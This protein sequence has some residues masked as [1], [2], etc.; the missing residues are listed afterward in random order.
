MT[1]LFPLGLLGLIGVPIIVIIYILRNKYNE[2]TVPSTY[3]WKLSERFFKRRNPLS[4]LT[5]IIS[6]ILQILTVITISLAVA[7]PIFVIPNSASE[8]CFVLDASGSMNMQ[9][10]NKTRFELAKSKIKK[11]INGAKAGS[12]YTL[13]LVSNET[14]SYERLT[15]KKLAIDTLS[16]F[17]CSDGVVSYTD[18]LAT[19]QRYFDE[20]PSFRVYLYTDKNYE[21][22]TN[23]ELVNVSN[24]NDVN[25]AL[26]DVESS[27]VNKTLTAKSNVTSY[28]SD[29]E[30]TV[31]LF[32]D[33]GKT[34]SATT[35]VSVKSGET[36]PVSLSTALESY[37]SFKLCIENEDALPTDNEFISYNQS[38]E[39]DYRILIVSETPFFLQAAFDAACDSEVDTL[40]P[41]EY[42]L[43]K[44]DEDYGLYVFHSYTPETLPDAAV[45]LINSTQS[46][47][48]SGFGI[49]GIE[50]LDSPAKLEKNDSTATIAQKLLTGIEGKDIYVKEYVKCS[51]MY[52]KFTTLFSY[53]SNPLLFAGV[54]ALGNRQV[55]F[56][57]D[58]HKAH[59]SLSID[60]SLLIANLLAYSCPDVLD[61]T[62]YVCGEEVNINIIANAKN[63]KAVAPDGAEIYIDSSTDLGVIRLNKVG[64]YTVRMNVSGEEKSYKFYSCA[65]TE[66]S[67][68]LP[69]G[70]AFSLAGEQQFEK[71]DG[72]YD[73]LAI[74]F[75]CLTLL[76]IADWMVYCYEKYQLR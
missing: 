27:L 58:L 23:I 74:L 41:E 1:F 36:V 38:S 71:T 60:K 42:D 10:E 72:T 44:A 70:L 47:E 68:P 67:D 64:T 9:S 20:N 2:Q 29:A 12:S 55:V 39:A 11:T 34:P 76:F 43:G 73:P 49:R 31:Q 45:W 19:A 28:A 65:P 61:R 14:T 3:L 18:A 66:E 62:G 59:F 22:H 26:G 37:S 24:S 69:T 46:V 33:D 6:L 51:G 5:G 48:D 30:L 63:V 7:R 75:I 57:F 8:Y 52:T 54:N 21:E 25:Y 35:K 50:E 17:E 53:N 40:T 32:V 13:V 4:G 15:D 16:D 56:A